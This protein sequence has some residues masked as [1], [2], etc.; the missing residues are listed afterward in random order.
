MSRSVWHSV[1]WSLNT[2]QEHT[3]KFPMLMPSIPMAAFVLKSVQVIFLS[4][5]QDFSVLFKYMHLLKVWLYFVSIKTS[6]FY[7]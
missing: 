2:I 3:A 7:C 4:H 6:C 1:R 5:I